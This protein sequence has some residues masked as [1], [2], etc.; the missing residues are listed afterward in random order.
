MADLQIHVGIDATGHYSFRMQYGAREFTTVVDPN[1]ATSFYEDLRLLRWKSIGARNPGDALLSDVGN[2]LANLIA[3]PEQWNALGLVREARLV[4][5]QFSQAAHRLMP[6]PWELLRVNDAFLIGER[7]SHVVREVPA[8]AAKDL[9]RN[10]LINIVHITL[11]TDNMLRFDDERCTLLETVPA[12]MPI[13]FLIAPSPDFV[14]LTLDSF[15]PH[16]VV[17]SGHG[18]YDDLEGEHFLSM[19]EDDARTAQLVAVCAS[20]GCELLV[21]STCESAR[22]GGPLI[23]DGTIL[24]AD[25]VA[26][27]FPVE[28]TTATQSLR[29]LFRTLVEGRTIADAMAA[30][31]ALD[32]EDEYAFFNPVHLHREGAP[33]LQIANAGAPPAGAPAPR[34]PGMELVLSTMNA[35]AHWETPTTLLAPVGSGGDAVVQHWA[36]LVRRSQTMSARWR[37]V[38]GDTPI[39]DVPGVQVVRLVHPYS[40]VPMPEENLV[41][42]DGMDKDLAMRL[43]ARCD[44]DLAR[45]VEKHPLLGMPIFVNDLLAGRMEEDAVQHFEQENRMAERAGRLTRD[46]ILF[47]SWLFANGSYS[48]TT[49]EDRATFAETMK[50]FGMPVPVIVTGIENAVAATVILAR[51]DGLLLAPEFMHLGERWFPNWRT[52]HRTAFRMLVGA[53]GMLADHGKIDPK[54]LRILNWAIRLEDWEVAPL[55]CIVLCRWFGEHGRLHEM[56]EIIDQ[57]VPHAEGLERIVLRGHLV[58]IATNHG[59]YR[60]G[61]TQNEQLETELQAFRD[62]EDYTKNLQATITQQIDCLIELNRLDDAERR[63]QDAHALV[64]QLGEDRAQS[65][66]RLMGQL[67]HLRREQSRSDEAIAAAS[68]AVRLAVDNECPEVLIAELRH[69]KADLLRLAERDREAVEELNLIAD[70]PMPPGL[71]SRFLHLKAVLLERYNSPDALEHFLESYQH[72]LLRRDHAGVAISLL[73]IARIYFDEHEYDHARERIREGLPLADKCGLVN[74]VARLSF[75]WAEIDLAEGK[76]TSAAAWLVTARNKFEEDENEG[77]VESTTRVLD[78]LR[79]IN[80]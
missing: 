79:E 7:G 47:A 57:L 40:F 21:L 62:H 55:L 25:L 65:E 20:Y 10:P 42:C 15:R 5:V 66:A 4:R 44:R 3:S 77:G 71:R 29:C 58:T 52:D 23:D 67:A 12:S 59:D 6:F 49:F 37:V 36:A 28:S 80:R 72:D 1:L 32:T 73:A 46:G 48:A 31:R 33:S 8:P 38:H 78:R 18:H 39:L 64:P 27:T 43:L 11:G 9:E 70:V 53:V 24:P 56:K 34:C 19:G 63:W 13:E 30:V 76:N 17:I 26:F 51:P 2:R 50:E 35:F 68:E 74:V 22:L 75:L 45:R 54:D 14:E 60:G 61:L 69:T 16:I 41:Y